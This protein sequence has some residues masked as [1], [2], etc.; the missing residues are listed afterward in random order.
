[1]GL[2]L[3]WGFSVS[4]EHNVGHLEER[5]VGIVCGSLRFQWAQAS[6]RQFLVTFSLSLVLCLEM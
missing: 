1:M 4:S 3:I 2:G 6:E 5:K